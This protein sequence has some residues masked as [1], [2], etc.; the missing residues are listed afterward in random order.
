[1]A[2]GSKIVGQDSVGGPPYISV[3]KRDG[4]V[5]AVKLHAGFGEEG[6]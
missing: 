4:Q 3:A 2:D 5:V 1:M 6:V